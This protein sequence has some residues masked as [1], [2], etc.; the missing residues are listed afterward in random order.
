[1]GIGGGACNPMSMSE[2]ISRSMEYIW[3]MRLSHAVHRH[4][5]GVLILDLA[6]PRV[7]SLRTVFLPQPKV[8]YLVLRPCSFTT[9]SSCCTPILSKITDTLPL[10][11]TRSQL[12]SA[13]Q[14]YRSKQFQR[15]GMESLEIQKKSNS[16]ET[17]RVPIPT[18]C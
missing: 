15:L 12:G 7:T 16:H 4:H 6:S 8:F 5:H 2:D 9:Y 10:C 11:L 3:F 1:M 13:D 18:I 14:I 17:C